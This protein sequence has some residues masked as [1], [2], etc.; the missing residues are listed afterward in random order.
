MW[1]HRDPSIRREMIVRQEW[2]GSLGSRTNVSVGLRH[3]PPVATATIEVD[4]SGWSPGLVGGEQHSA[5]EHQ[6]VGVDR[7]GAVRGSLRARRAGA[8]RR[9]VGRC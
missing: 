8:V 5:L 6:S 2:L 3:V 4:I 9:S 7:V 1:E